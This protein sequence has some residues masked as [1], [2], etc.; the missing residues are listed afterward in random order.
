MKGQSF[1]MLTFPLAL[2]LLTAL[3][4]FQLLSTPDPLGALLLPLR[5]QN[6]RN[7]SISCSPDAFRPR[8]ELH[9]EDHIYRDPVTQHLEWVITSDSLRPDGVLK[10]AILINGN[11]SC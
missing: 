7:I 8:I 9:S 2:C 4:Y 5:N 10:Q 11:N 3:A 6:E 1:W